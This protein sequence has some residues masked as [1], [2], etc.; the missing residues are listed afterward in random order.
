M[1]RNVPVAGLLALAVVAMIGVIT[2]AAA[3]TTTPPPKAGLTKTQQ[4]ALAAGVQGNADS[5]VHP[6]PSDPPLELIAPP[7]ELGD[8]VFSLA[9]LAAEGEQRSAAEQK[10]RDAIEGNSPTGQTGDGVLDDILGVIKSRPS[11]LDNSSLDPNA[12]SGQTN[13][14][15]TIS[16][17]AHTA[18]QLLKASRLLEGVGP[19]D[20]NRSD[21]VH[22]MRAEAEKL[23]SE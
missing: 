20:E 8:P 18:E 10:I 3:E 19:D 7:F 9:E 12:R 5:S 13:G 6:K 2:I 22:R 11:I 17:K 4:T 21:L 16:K 1:P 23:L 15:N 14:P